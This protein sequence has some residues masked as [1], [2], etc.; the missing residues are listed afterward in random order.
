MNNGAKNRTFLQ[1]IATDTRNQ[2][3]DSLAANYGCS[4]S[5]VLAEVTDRGAENL[6]DYIGDQS[7][8]AATSVLMQKHSK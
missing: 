8:R 7:L 1:S 3:L 4:R 2:I 5:A 6:L